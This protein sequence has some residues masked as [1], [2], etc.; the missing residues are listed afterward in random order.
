MHF[1]PH[2]YGNTTACECASATA[3]KFLQQPPRKKNMK[4]RR[5]RRKIIFEVQGGGVH[6]LF[7]YYFARSFE[8]LYAGNA[9]NDAA[10]NVPHTNCRKK[11]Q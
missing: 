6:C 7:H 4:R 1:F 8:L 5:R 2:T 11:E 10:F 9:G 3:L